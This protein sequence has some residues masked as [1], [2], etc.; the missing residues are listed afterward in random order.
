V[1]RL[2]ICTV[3]AFLLAAS[4]SA[5]PVR[6][7]SY[8]ELLKEADVVAIV[9]VTKIEET[10]ARF[11]EH[12][13]P[14]WYQGKLAHATVGLMLKGDARRT[15]SF[16]FFNYLPKFKDPPNGAWFANLSKAG[17][18]HYLVFLKKT[19]GGDWAPATGHYDAGASICVVAPQGPIEINA[20]PAK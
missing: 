12:G 7:W 16:Q 9:K 15:L 2:L 6:L 11:E 3:A 20:A 5:R 8:E 17:Q 18:V 19:V 10:T 14:G 13:D 1:H 4:A